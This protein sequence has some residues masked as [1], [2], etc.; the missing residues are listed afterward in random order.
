MSPLSR[1]EFVA[2]GVAAGA[3]TTDRALRAGDDRRVPGRLVRGRG[4]RGGREDSG[5]D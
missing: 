4:Q 1:R 3:G 5:A 2:A